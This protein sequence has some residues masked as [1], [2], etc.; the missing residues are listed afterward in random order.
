MSTEK[1]NDNE[2]CEIV[3]EKPRRRRGPGKKETIRNI[4]QTITWQRDQPKFIVRIA[5]GWFV[6]GSY[7]G[8]FNY[9]FAPGIQRIRKRFRKLK[10][11][12]LPKRPRLEF[13][14]SFLR[15]IEFF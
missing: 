9:Q 4:M 14:T 12:T 3:E 13:K 5:R 10:T 11:S 1:T 8:T 2:V 15:C 7:T 6:G